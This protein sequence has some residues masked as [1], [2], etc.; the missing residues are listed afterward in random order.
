MA[1]IPLPPFTHSDFKIFVSFH[2]FYFSRRDGQTYFLHS[3]HKSQPFS[4]I[5]GTLDE[6]DAGILFSA[7]RKVIEMSYGLLTKHNL[8]VFKEGS[9]YQNVSRD[10]LQLCKPNLQ[11]VN[12]HF[13]FFRFPDHNS[14]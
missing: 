5:T 10:M 11:V 12:F 4:H 14:N 9:M 6:L 8:E 3:S 1:T 7:G 13:E 2:L